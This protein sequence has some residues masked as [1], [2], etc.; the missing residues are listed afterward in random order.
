MYGFLYDHVNKSVEHKVPFIKR[1]PFEER[2]KESLR[3]RQKYPDRIPVIVERFHT[4]KIPELDKNKF[5]VPTD[6]TIGALTFTIRKR[7]RLSPVES[8]FL[9][10]G[11][12]NILAPAGT[13]IYTL[14][15]DNKNEDG[16][17]YVT[18]CENDT[19]GSFED[20]INVV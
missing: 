17:L 1:V 11:D 20:S 8:M 2:C 14:Y 9:F 12:K 18:F 7:I 4:S 15:I 16:F 19:F 6:L 3:I 13:D 5:L 10:I